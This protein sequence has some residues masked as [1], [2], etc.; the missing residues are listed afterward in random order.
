MRKIPEHGVSI[1]D[2]VKGLREIS[3]VMRG[4]SPIQPV[5]AVLGKAIGNKRRKA[6]LT[7]RELARCLGKTREWLSSVESGGQRLLVH[8]LLEIEMAFKL[9]G[10]RGSV[11]STA[12]QRAVTEDY[13]PPLP[14][15]V[16]W[17]V[18][19][20]SQ[21]VL[22][23]RILDVVHAGMRDGNSAHCVT[24]VIMAV[25]KAQGRVV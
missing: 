11:T 23:E 9:R 10:D 19:S 3:K 7:Q 13:V 20:P 14:M 22:Q 18:G 12:R 6:G 21:N 16:P 8:D 25:I 15:D 5:Y 17:E 24:A 4:D 1:E 2:A